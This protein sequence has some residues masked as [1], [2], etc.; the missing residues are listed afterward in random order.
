MPS[1]ERDAIK[2][3]FDIFGAS[4]V[5]E[6]DIKRALAYLNSPPDYF[7][8]FDDKAKIDAA[9]RCEVIGSSQILFKD[10][11]EVRAKIANETSEAAYTWHTSATVK[12]IIK[13][14]SKIEYDCGASNQVV[15]KLM[16]MNSEQ[17]KNYLIRLVKDNYKIGIEILTE[18]E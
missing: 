13:D 3:I 12:K 15:E 17:A 2:K 9:F 18:G 14:L 10:V 4:Y 8:E 5:K 16:A 7:K 6:D 1:N 11:D